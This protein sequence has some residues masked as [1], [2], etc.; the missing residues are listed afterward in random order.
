MNHDYIGTE[1]ILL[2]LVH[3]GE[4]L[5]S[6]VLEGQGIDRRA[7]RVEVERLVPRGSSAI[8]TRQLPFTPH[9]KNVLEFT[10]EEATR[11]GHTKITTGHLLLGLLREREGIASRVLYNLKLDVERARSEVLQRIGTETN[12]YESIPAPRAEPIGTSGGEGASK[13]ADFTIHA[14]KV[15]EHAIDEASR[16]GHDRLGTGHLLLGLLRQSDG[17]AAAVLRTFNVNPVVAREEI[18][19]R[20]ATSEG[21]EG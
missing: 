5:A 16:L 19:K 7:S 2:A 11:L 8:F 13:L 10:L 6:N 20:I 3:E 15:V 21:G 4:G 14:K 18:L 9:A 12:A 1:H 17:I